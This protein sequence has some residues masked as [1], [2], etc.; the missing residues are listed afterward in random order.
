MALGL[1]VHSVRGLACEWIDGS[2]NSA[3]LP[4][5]AFRVMVISVFRFA[6]AFREFPERWGFSKESWRRL[7]FS[8]FRNSRNVEGSPAEEVVA[9]KLAIFAEPAF[10]LST[11]TFRSL[12]KPRQN[13]ESARNCLAMI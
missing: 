8:R 13:A 6:F 7:T 9:S 12:E 1:A 2:E 3:G 4:P 5:V 11:V 10:G